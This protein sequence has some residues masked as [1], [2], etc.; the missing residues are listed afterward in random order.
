MELIL[1]HTVLNMLEV[2]TFPF[3]QRA[4]IAGVSS[5]FV[6]GWLGAFLTTKKMSFLGDGIAH[7]SLVGVAIALFFGWPILPVS[8]IIAFIIAILIYLLE[9]NAKLSS[10]SAIGIIFTTSMALG[11]I[12]LS[13]YQGYQPELI[14]YLFGN[15]LIISKVD[16]VIILITNLIVIFILSFFFR[17]MVF[18][19]FDK[20]GAY[21]SGIDTWKYDLMLYIISSLVIVLCIK[22]IGII[23]VSAL[24]IIPSAI[25]KLFSNSFKTFTIFS[26]LLAAVLVFFGLILSYYLDL[27]SGA[28]IILFSVFTLGLSYFGRKLAIYMIR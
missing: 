28:T 3:M 26:S 1:I 11:V 24:M 25:A 23:L 17:K 18:T 2:F 7:A 27:P 20:D 14:S 6:L 10:D 16:L 4:F 9:S 21:L 13:L 8:L 22:L 5:G 15:I 12:I 19:I